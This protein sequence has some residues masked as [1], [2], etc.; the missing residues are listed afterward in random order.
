MIVYIIR[1]GPNLIANDCVYFDSAIRCVVNHTR[2][3]MN[4][5]HF[6]EL[7][8]T[9]TRKR[10]GDRRE[11]SE[12]NQ[13]VRPDEPPCAWQLVAADSAAL[14]ARCRFPGSPGHSR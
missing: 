4:E 7:N 5:T 8:G 12:R 3:R 2:L 9:R 13:E 6:G 10:D 11:A 1:N 14:S